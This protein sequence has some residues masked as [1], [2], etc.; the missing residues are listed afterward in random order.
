MDSFKHA[1]KLSADNEGGISEDR[2]DDGNFTV[3]DGKKYFISTRY[4]LT[5]NTWRIKSGKKEPETKKDYDALKKEFEK[6]TTRSSVEG[7]FKTHYWDKNNLGEIKDKD[8]ASNIYDALINQTWSFGGP[9][10]HKTLADTLES[11]GYDYDDELTNEEAVA[12]VN[13]AIKEKGADVFNDAYSQRRETSYK[14]SKT[15]KEHGKGWLKRLNQ[16]RSKTGQVK[17]DEWSADVDL[18]TIR[19]ETKSAKDDSDDR[20]DSTT[21]KEGADVVETTEALS[22][23]IFQI[24]D[25]VEKKNINITAVYDADSKAWTYSSEDESISQEKVDELGNY[26]TTVDDPANTFKEFTD[27][28]GNKYYQGFVSTEGGEQTAFQKRYTVHQKPVQLRVDPKVLAKIDEERDKEQEKKATEGLDENERKRRDAQDVQ[29]DEERQLITNVNDALKKYEV[30]GLPGDKRAYDKAKANL[31]KYRSEVGKEKK[32]EE[33][34]NKVEIEK[35]LRKQLQMM[36]DDPE[37]FSLDELRNVKAQIDKVSLEI[38]DINGDARTAGPFGGTRESTTDVEYTDI[39]ELRTV[40]DDYKDTREAVD[41]GDVQTVSGE[42]VEEKEPDPTVLEDVEITPEEEGDAELDAELSEDIINYMADNRTT[43]GKLIAGVG[44]ASGIISAVIGAA[45]LSKA[46]KPITQEDMPKLSG[47]FLDYLEQTRKLSEQGFS[48]AEEAK[49]RRDI[50]TSYKLGV[51]NL[52]KGTA[53]DRA[54]FLAMSGTLD[55]NRSRALLDFAAKDAQMNRINLEGYGKVLT[56]SEDVN[57]ENE[58]QLRTERMEE[59]MANKQMSSDVAASAFKNL[60]DEIAYQKNNGPG[61]INHAIKTARLADLYGVYPDGTPING[62]NPN[63][64]SE[65]REDK[66]KERKFLLNEAIEEGNPDAGKV[67]VEVIKSDVKEEKANTELEETEAA[68]SYQGQEDLHRKV[69][70]LQDGV[71]E[72]LAKHNNN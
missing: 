68:A 8:V 29:S 15:Y 1:H 35:R 63:A 34:S 71:R 52:I 62:D 21:T 61:S 46:M 26:L 24:Y 18:N 69:L 41:T 44:G 55:A 49:A 36:K 9:G 4:G 59:Q 14:G 19:V 32:S 6:S 67:D 13:K 70:E 16:Y 65:E 56:Y 48:P 45:A 51:E 37:A 38:A 25:N 58:L 28:D 54:K 27:D 50:N 7:F 3:V 43:A 39:D 12:S 30:S 10:T 40:G 72:V 2:G 22:D 31:D 5:F 53:G 60:M 20:K 17:T 11:L 33:L 47:A 64:T 42:F 57:R 66:E 23:N